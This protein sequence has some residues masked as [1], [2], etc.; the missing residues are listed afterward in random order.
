MKRR[1]LVFLAALCLLAGLT[2]PVYAAGDTFIADYADLL[3]AEEERML[4]AQM[5]NAA[6]S[7]DCGVYIAAVDDCGQYGETPYDAAVQLY[8]ELTMYGDMPEDG[9]LLMLSMRERDYSLITYGAYAEAVFTD[10]VMWDMEDAF[11][12]EFAGNRWFSGFSTY[13]DDAG[14]LL[15]GFHTDMTDRYGDRYESYYDPGVPQ[16]VLRANRIAPELW[17]AVAGGSLAVALVVCLIMKAGM[18]TARKATHADA[19]I[20]AGGVNL[21]IK[22]DR[23]THTTT[24]VVHHP[25]S[26]GGGR[27]GGGGG[28]FRGHSGKF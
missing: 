12:Y 18:R 22:Q 25:K 17:L 15:R 26:N 11:L 5:R 21:R 27:V 14:T 16:V 24:R 6:E 2:V 28:G 13:V 19:Y 7:Y 20:P 4:T 23:F 8:A 3:T 1:V 9:I 10:E